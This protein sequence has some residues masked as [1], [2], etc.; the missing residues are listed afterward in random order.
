MW[1]VIKHSFLDGIKLLPIVFIVYLIIEYLETKEANKE[2]LKTNF[3]SKN[4]P[5]FGGL[6]GVVPQ[7]GFSV[8]STKLYEDG[9]IYLGTLLAVYL[10]TSDEAIPILLSKSVVNPNLIFSLVLLILIKVAYGVLIGY[11]VN[12]IGIKY[13]KNN[14]IKQRER[15]HNHNNEV[16]IDGGCCGHNVTE[17]RNGFFQFILHPLI[18]SLKIICYIIIINVVLGFVIDV[19]IGEESFNS[20][21]K[22]SKILQPLV[23]CLVGIIPNCASSVVISQLFANGTLTFS[24]TLGGLC[25]NSGLGIAILFKNRKLI[26]RNLLI[27]LLIFCLSLVIGYVAL[28]VE[29]II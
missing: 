18:H 11:L 19:W 24:A 29:V 22:Q 25:A 2:K 8:I 23:C 3:Q 5:L 10:A 7:C 13:F 16:D 27:L 6:I 4:A 14:K 26:K 9:Y 12:F 28:S 20:F 1:H 17:K 15:N 21:L